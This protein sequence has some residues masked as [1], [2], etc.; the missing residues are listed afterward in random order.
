MNKNIIVIGASAGG[1]EAIGKITNFLPEDFSASIFIVIHTGKDSPGW[2]D[3]ILEA[4]STLP[5]KYVKARELIRPGQIYLPLVDHHLILDY[6]N[7]VCITRGPKENRFRPAID[8]LFRSAAQVYQSRV[9]GV[10]LTGGLD[11]GTAGLQTIKQLGGT[12]IVQDPTEAENPSMPQSALKHVQVDHCIPSHEIAPMLIKLTQ[13]YAKDMKELP[14]ADEITTEVKIASE[15]APLSA[16]I[17]K[18]GK[19]SIYTCPECHGTLLEIPSDQLVRYRCHT[20]HAYTA[21]SLIEDIDETLENN[22]WSSIR[23]VDEQMLLL[24]QMGEDAHQ[25]GDHAAAEQLFDKARSADRRAKTL[26][27]V[28]LNLKNL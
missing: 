6:D 10:I 9:I 4:R 22:L 3:T 11:D 14:L 13:Q 18:L 5:V 26:R 24:R 21:E 17:L 15:H 25:N 7:I 27:E 8:P 19:P 28:V 1:I 23:V 20:G 16:G 2:L 12:S